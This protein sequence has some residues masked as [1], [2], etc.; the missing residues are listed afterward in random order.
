M[1]AS[2][3]SVFLKTSL[4]VWLLRPSTISPL[5]SVSASPFWF[6]FGNGLENLDFYPGKTLDWTT[7]TVLYLLP[8]PGLSSFLSAAVSPVPPGEAR[9]PRQGL[10]GPCLSIPTCTASRCVRTI[11]WLTFVFSAARVRQSFGRKPLY[12][13]KKGK[14]IEKITISCI[15]STLY[16]LQAW[17]VRLYTAL[18]NTHTCLLFY[19]IKKK[20][21]KN[22]VSKMQMLGAPLTGTDHP[23]QTA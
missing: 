8:L 18:W 17:P 6:G 14:G 16:G 2:A 21:T 19:F 22:K 7:G 10:S 11:H 15:C 4:S 12:F 3:C 13:W 1:P 9:A 5:G 23:G 20:K